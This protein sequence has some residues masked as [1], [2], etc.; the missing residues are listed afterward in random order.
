M[1]SDLL[2]KTKKEEIER[3]NGK[4]EFKQGKLLFVYLVYCGFTII[5]A[6]HAFKAIFDGIQSFKESWTIYLYK[7]FKFKA[8]IYK[9]KRFENEIKCY[10]MQIKAL[11]QR[12]K[13]EKGE[14]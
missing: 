12:D 5:E 13:L 9:Q 1:K 3:I 11:Q 4:M 6:I 7:R 10:E 8:S 14:I 2:I